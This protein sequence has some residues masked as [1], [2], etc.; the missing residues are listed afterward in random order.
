MYTSFWQFYIYITTSKGTSMQVQALKNYMLL[1]KG[2]FIC[3]NTKIINVLWCYRLPYDN[4]KFFSCWSQPWFLTCLQFGVVVCKQQCLQLNAGER[5]VF[6]NLLQQ[7]GS[8]GFWLQQCL[9]LGAEHRLC[10]KH[11]CCWLQQ[12]CNTCASYSNVC[13]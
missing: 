12:C 9:Q 13:S 1:N 7:C 11:M 4:T 10:C 3:Y 8:H 6:C 5:R 2:Y